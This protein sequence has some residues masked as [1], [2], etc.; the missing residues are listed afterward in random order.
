MSSLPTLLRSS[1]MQAAS[2]TEAQGAAGTAQSPTDESSSYAAQ[3]PMQSQQQR[4]HQHQQGNFQGPASSMGPAGVM[5]EGD[6][7]SRQTLEATG[8]QDPVLAE[9]WNDLLGGLLGSMGT[10]LV[11]LVW[12]MGCIGVPTACVILAGSQPDVLHGVYL[13]IMLAYL[14]ASCS[15]LQPR[16]VTAPQWWLQY[17]CCNSSNTSG[18]RPQTS[19][20]TT[21]AQGS[22]QPQTLE[23]TFSPQQPQEQPHALPAAQLLK[24]RL[25][26][27]YGSC[28]LLVVYLALVLQLPGL[29]SEMNEYVLRLVGLWDPKIL[30]DL[31]PVLLLLVAATI[32]VILGKWLLTRPPAGAAWTST[33][34]TPAAAA[35]DMATA[36][37]T[38]QHCTA[39]VAAAAGAADQSAGQGRP[40]FWEWLQVVYAKPVLGI[41]VAG[42]KLAC[43]VGSGLLV[44]LV[45]NSERSLILMIYMRTVQCGSTNCAAAL[46]LTATS[47][48]LTDSPSQLYCVASFALAYC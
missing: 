7:P 24:H 48:A 25:L 4:Q 1:S 40:S 16:P 17:A 13:L 10:G 41:L 5:A 6:E 31:L 44:L 27:L 45:S 18:D 26:R 32:H 9:P 38:A 8:F 36:G 15:G 37:L 2:F 28:H 11:Q 14:L 43:S 23:Q 19:T 39:A 30:A 22:S 35:Q 46:T 42:A 20:Q 3:Q 29:D 21:A 12:L 47:S 33:A 34:R